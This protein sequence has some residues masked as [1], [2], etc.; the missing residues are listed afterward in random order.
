VTRL[1]LWNSRDDL[2]AS[3]SA[4]KKVPRSD[5]PS[6]PNSS[7]NPEISGGF[8]WLRTPFA[9]LSKFFHYNIVFFLIITRDGGDLDVFCNIDLLSLVTIFQYAAGTL[10]GVVEFF[11]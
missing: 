6:T 7:G 5:T 8:H 2:P 4:L 3:K 10:I 11:L 9:D 1:I